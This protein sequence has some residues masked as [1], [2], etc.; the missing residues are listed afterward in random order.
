MSEDQIE[1]SLNLITSGASKAL[2]GLQNSFTRSFKSMNFDVGKTTSSF[3]SMA[4][5]LFSVRNA[6][7]AAGTSIVTYFASKEVISK[8]IESEEAINSVALALART[9]KYS[10]ESLGDLEQWAATLQKQTVYEDDAILKQTAYAMAL[11]VTKDKVKGVIAASIE[12]SAATG[13]SLEESVTA[14]SKTFNGTARELG[15]IN[16][17]IK[18]LTESQLRNGDAVK[19]LLEQ[20]GGT[21]IGKL[22]A[23][24]GAMAQN[25]NIFGDFLEQVGFLITKNPVVIQGIKAMSDIFLELTKYLDKNRDSIIQFVNEGIIAILESGPKVGEVLKFIVSGLTIMTKS[26]ALAS[27]GVGIILQSLLNFGPIKILFDGLVATIGLVVGGIV[28]LLSVLVKLPGVSDT[29][30]AMGFDVEGLSTALGKAAKGAYGVMD[31]FSSDAIS[32]SI[33]KANEFAFKVADGATEVRDNLNKAI[34]EGVV[35]AGKLAKTV[36]DIAAKGK[37][38]LHVVNNTEST[39]KSIDNYQQLLE[40]AFGGTNGAKIGG[41]LVA[42]IANGLKNGKEGA[43]AM[44]SSLAGAAAD[45][46][47]PGLGAAVGPLVD[48]LSMGP[49]AVRDM[50]KQ[51]MGAIP[52]LVENIIE[53][54]PVLVEEFANQMPIIITKLAE[55]A[56]DI[57]LALVKAMPKAAIAL[58]LMMPKV[59]LTFAQELIKNLP[60]IVGEAGRAIYEAVSK[61]L[62]QLTGGVVGGKSGSAAGGSG[63]GGALKTGPTSNGYVNAGLNVVTLGGSGVA[64]ASL[65]KLGVKFAT[66]GEVP[67]GYPNDSFPARLS[68]KELVID[69]TVSP[70]LKKFL[71]GEGSGTTDVLLAKVIDLLEKPMMVQ[72]TAKVNQREFANIILQLNRTQQ[73]TV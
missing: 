8:A 27:A 57:I 17:R 28:D 18:K 48:A 12:L 29:L 72:S 7:I 26:L 14:V 37:V 59:A 58:S 51:F 71:D 35:K 52:G 13:K 56:D 46:F 43:R 4:K 50:V 38:E 25:K 32:K 65:K 2:D 60:K 33:D 1:V 23:F 73:R 61:A 49:E 69:R 31:S 21:A 63:V 9:G 11:G 10:R 44:L 30:Q 40:T 64:S 34:D 41:A 42:G 16:G 70:R 67:D 62:S 22:N 66:G 5:N 24:G 39:K 47:L 55:R 3:T 15:Q 36:K 53:A 20:Y 45:A 54:V 19:V 6:A 68:S